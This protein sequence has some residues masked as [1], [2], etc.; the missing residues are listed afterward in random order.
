MPARCPQP[1]KLGASILGPLARAQG[2][3]QRAQAVLHEMLPDGPATEPGTLPFIYTLPVLR[4][5]AALA[6]DGGDGDAARAWLETHDRWLAWNNAVLGRAEGHLA[7]AEYHRA[8]GDRRAAEQRATD[9]LAAA[10]QPRQPLALLAA[11]RLLG[12]LATEAQ[13]FDGAASQFERSLALAEACAAPYER[14]L[15]L[16]AQAEL[17]AVMGARPEAR[18]FLDRARALTI[19]LGAKPLLARIDA[20]GAR[21]AA[22]SA[23]HPTGLTQREVEVL[24]LLAA[25]YSNRAIGDALGMSVRTAERHLNNIYVKTNARGRTDAT[26]FALRHGLADVPAT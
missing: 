7:W 1:V 10:T 20:L 4:L 6:L 17:R 8:A 26:A 2:D 9:A 5:A 12:E 22:R 21:V 24:R 11:H 13:Q 23:T 14:A 16:L 19:P 18:A 25:G 3:T 15:T